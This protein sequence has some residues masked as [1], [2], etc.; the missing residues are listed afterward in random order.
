MLLTCPLC[1]FKA[2]LVVFVND[3]RGK[4][5]AALMGRVPPPLSDG[6]QRYLHLF[7]PAK[8]GL[9]ISR[10]LTLLEPLVQWIEAGRITRARREWVITLAQFEAAF[11]HMAE[12]RAKLTLPLKSHGYLLEVLSGMADKLEA[13]AEAKG[14]EQ[15]RQTAPHASAQTEAQQWDEGRRLAA[16]QVS[17]VR[18]LAGEIA[19]CKKLNTPFT[20]KQ[21]TDLLAQQGHAPAAIQFA[22]TKVPLE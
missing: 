17:A 15:Q 18:A 8:H 22:F 4:Q 11:E 14:I 16:A 7:A 1:A 10:F 3:K 12:S 20:R 19:A 21:L 6:I 2:D 9:T 5:A 13:Q